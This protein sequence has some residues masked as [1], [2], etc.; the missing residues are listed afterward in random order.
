MV[1]EGTDFV[2]VGRRLPVTMGRH[3]LHR[4]TMFGH[5]QK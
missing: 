2:N 5:L 1:Q 4:R 3:H